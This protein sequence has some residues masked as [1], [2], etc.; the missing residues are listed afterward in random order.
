MKRIL[1]TTSNT[2]DLSKLR[3]DRQREA[4]PDNGRANR[5]HVI[6]FAG[7]ATA[8][9]SAF[10]LFSRG[11]L[12]SDIEVETYTV[13]A[14]S[15]AQ[16]DAVLTA[17]GY[18]VAQRQAAVA[19][20]ATGRLEYLGAEE[21][22]Q[23][24]AG[25]II[26]RLESNDV[27]AA[28]AQAQANLA[29]A[30]AQL[31]QSEADRQEATLQF[32]RYKKLLAEQIVARADFDAAEARYKR[33]VAAV[34]AD[35]AAIRAAEAAARAAEVALENTNIRAPFDGTVLT[36]NAD[37]GEIVAPFGS[38]SSARAAVVSIA[39]MASLEVEAD[40]SESNIQRIKPGQPCEIV[41]D[42]YPDTRYPGAVSKIVPTADRAKAT[43]LTK[44]KFVER[45]ERVLPE[46]SAK[47]AFLSKVIEK[48]KTDSE[49]KIVI[50]PAAITARNDAKLVFVV[51]DD[52]AV[53]TPVEL[54]GLAGSMIEVVSGLSVGDRIVL[55]PSPNMATGM[56]VKLVSN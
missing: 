29:A 56:K 24:R 53:E 8:V 15:P 54:G 46:M 18:V 11:T 36:K 43:V 26:A 4:P 39:D 34:T 7:I 6:L 14:I 33:A 49:K 17:S 52:R 55:D 9:A 44:I 35:S 30:K 38:A 42:A 45:D 22:D 25:Q 40:V 5:K 32:E 51:R 10:L 47:V 12:G 27:A 1:M 16:A 2:A 20:K 28:L 31:P 19:S 21:G 50:P 3:I 13:A 37:V 23:V 48:K 41:L